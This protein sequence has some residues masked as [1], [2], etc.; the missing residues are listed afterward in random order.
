MNTEFE[1]ANSDRVRLCEK[2]DELKRKVTQAQQERDTAQ[3]SF[4][5]E[6]SMCSGY[7]MRSIVRIQ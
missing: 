1:G 7:S 2:V 4:T 5:K 3:R 6:V